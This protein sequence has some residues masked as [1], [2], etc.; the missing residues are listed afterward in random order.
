MKAR[1]VPLL[2]AAA[3]A[4]AGCSLA[5]SDDAP[6]GTVQVVV[7][8]QS[9]TINTV[10]AGTL[11]RAKGFLEQRLAAITAA[12]GA[13]YQV[14][15]QDYDTGAPITAQMV[16]EKIDIG[17]M[18]DYPLLINGSRTQAN[19]RSATALVSVTGYNPKGA[20]NMVVVPTDSPATRLADL[21]GQ[22]VSASV[23]SAGHG[24]LVQALSR[25]GIDP[26]TGVEVVNQQPQVGASALESHQVSGLSQ[27][28]AWPGLLVFQN[29]AKLLYD[30]AELNVP[31]FHG[32]VA[33][34]AY[35]AE[36]PE[37]LQAFLAAQLDATRFLNEQPF[38]AARLVAEGSGLPQEVVYL[39]NGPGGT[40]FDP[41]V[42]PSLI[43]ALKGDVPYLKSIGDFA[44][45]DIDR[46]VD[47]AP[48]REAFAAFGDYDTALA[49]TGNPNR[50]RGTDPVCGTEVT[51]PAT[52]GEVWVD[53][54]PA[55]QPAADP[56]CLLRAVRAAQA[57]G[58]VIRA[59]YVP[60][61]ELGT[62]WF[63]DKSVW[64]RDGDRYLPFTTAAAAER[65]RQAHPGAAPV[66]YE[67]AVRE[68]RP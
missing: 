62:R 11:L 28:V 64:V 10:T 9:K 57:N 14:E 65:Y 47:P 24:T 50:V 40:S 12:G 27:F 26:A 1:L 21:A 33:R 45:L 36:H 25:A 63:A 68:V 22:K 15:W 67:Q 42:K 48:L 29:K 13:R 41:I 5:P 55:P 44:D 59:A 23:G 51:D 37:V 30:G 31:T 66:S 38:E 3:L 49:A 7:G 32:V 34:R 39:Y 46:F 35:S 52:A 6:A 43:E 17:S 2:L 61:A 60:D 4:A 54:A 53:G 16:A 18:G 8:Y 20:L 58:A 56:T 19:E